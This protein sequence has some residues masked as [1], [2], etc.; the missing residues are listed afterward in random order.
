MTCEAAILA[1][2]APLASDQALASE[3]SRRALQGEGVVFMDLGR[4]NLA[5]TV[6]G[7]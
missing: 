4:P 5:L 3:L 2:T 7:Q 1:C 6:S